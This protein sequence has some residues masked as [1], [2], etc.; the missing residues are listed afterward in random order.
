MSYTIRPINTGFTNI[1]KELY[2][3]HHSTKIKFKETGD[4]A[5]PCFVFLIEGGGKKIMVDTSTAPTERAHKYHHAGSWQPEG[6]SI[7]E[8]LA[9]LGMTP[10][11]IDIVLFTHLHWDH[12]YFM[13]QFTNATFFVHKA[14]LEF[15]LDPIPVYYKSY[16]HPS[17]GITRPFEGVDFE[18]VDGEVEIMDGIRYVPTPGHSPGHMN[19]EV[20]GETGVYSCCGDVAFLYDNFEAIPEIHYTISPPARYVNIVESY[21]SIEL[22]KNRAKSLDYILLTHEPSLMERVEKEPVLK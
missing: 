5:V 4:I 7:P 16:E 11:D 15:A 2:C 9:D 8:R 12:C 10:K 22:T 13:E 18:I 3:Y 20:T 6:Y 1:E 19:I 21:R 17:L 14:E